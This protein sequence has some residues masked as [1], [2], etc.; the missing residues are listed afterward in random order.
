MALEQ[1]RILILKA[2]PRT[3]IPWIPKD[4]S[5]FRADSDNPE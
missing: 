2:S 5:N 4:R 1:L 3:N